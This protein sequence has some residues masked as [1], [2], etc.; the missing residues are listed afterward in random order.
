MG[1]RCGPEVPSVTR[2]PP[3][4]ELRTVAMLL[5]KILAGVLI[6]YGVVLLLA[7]KFQE[8]LAFPGHRVRLVDPKRAGLPDGEIVTLVTSDGL[9]LK[10]WYLPPAPAPP[11]SS[12]APGLIW[13]YGNLESVSGLAPVIRELRPPAVGILVLDYR[14][15]G[16]SPGRPTE[17]GLYR[18]ADAAWSFLASRPELDATRI[19]VY[20]RSLGSAVALYLADTK[21]VAAV[22]LDSPF[23][24]ARE[25]ARWHYP[26]LPPWVLRLKLD[27]LGRARRLRVPLLVFHGTEDRIVPPR[28]GRAIALA[29]QARELVWIQG[30]DHNDTYAV[31]LA[32]YRKKLHQFLQS[33]L[34]SE[35]RGDSADSEG[36]ESGSS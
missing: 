11:S 5:I 25:M 35:R 17:A 2:V 15:Y 7:W 1:P 32:Q 31:D 28:M 36:T 12:K 34:V 3:V 18:D 20:G 8:R 6:S 19:A 21:P 29:G 27:N 30:A 16:E 23:T 14:G 10:G 24:T 4:T 9:A 13:F 22:V 26:I 33:V